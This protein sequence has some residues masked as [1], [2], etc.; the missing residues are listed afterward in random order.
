MNESSTP[1][2]GTNPYSAPR[3]NEIANREDE[4]PQEVKIFSI[5][6]RIGRVRYIGYSIGLS[7]L[8][9]LVGAALGAVTFG[10]GIFI[11]YIA[12]MVMQFMLTIQRCHDFDTSGWLSLLVL[13]PLVNLVFWFIPGTDG[14][15]RW[16]NNTKPNSGLDIALACIVPLVFVIGVLAAIA[17]PQYAK[18]VEKA[19]QSQMK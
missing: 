18:Y 19:K 2:T 15:N 1:Q 12:L 5:R 8:I 14:A 11:A 13:I 7:I 6:G 10:I 3:A 16:G 9:M 17:I 4:T